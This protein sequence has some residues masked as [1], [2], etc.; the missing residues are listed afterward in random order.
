M[1]TSRAQIA[2]RLQPDVKI[3]AGTAYADY[4]TEYTKI[5]TVKKSDKAYE[6][7]VMT[8]GL[9]LA[10]IKHEGQQL[11]VSDVR[12]GF[13]SRADHVTLAIGHMITEEAIEDN[14]Y[15]ESGIRGAQ[16]IGR[17]LAQTKETR[18]ANILNNGFT[19]TMGD[20]STF[21]ADAHQLAN[22]D[23][24]DNLLTGDISETVL[25]SVWTQTASWVD[26]AGLKVKIMPNMLIVSPSDYFTA[27]EIMKSDKST[28]TATLGA[29][30]ITSTNNI[31][32]LKSEG[33]F[34]GGMMVSHY[35]TDADSFFVK[36]DAAK[37]GLVLWQRRNATFKLD[38]QD[39]FSGNILETGSERYSFMIS[40]P[41]VMLASRGV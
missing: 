41:R 12:D 2:K 22:G 1:A 28:T 15:T 4:A 35:L 7:G 17:S 26:D 14:L 23:T 40:D 37:D 13:V 34:P 25:K 38:Y 39:P 31:N 6:E 5:F 16:M 8:A 29:T 10:Q 9:P 11:F 20:G 21:F 24:L 30:G 19:D 36:T 32:S 18:A 3:I 33:I 27:V